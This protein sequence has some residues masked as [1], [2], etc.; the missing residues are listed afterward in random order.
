MPNVLSE[1]AREMIEDGLRR[2][3]SVREIVAR[4]GVSKA[5]VAKAKKRVGAVTCG[6]G[7]VS[8]HRGFCKETYARKEGRQAWQRSRT[9]E[10]QAD[11]G[12]DDE[13]YYGPHP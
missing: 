4:V 2:G 9:E 6:C 7:E 5:S 8:G 1:R 12:E 10:G 11:D 13:T 3:L